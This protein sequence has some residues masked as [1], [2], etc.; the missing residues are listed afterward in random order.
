MATWPWRTRSSANA[1]HLILMPLTSLTKK[2]TKQKKI[3]V[4]AVIVAE[5]GFRS[6]V[7]SR[8]L[9]VQGHAWPPRYWLQLISTSSS[10]NDENLQKKNQ[11]DSIHRGW[12]S[13]GHINIEGGIESRHRSRSSN[14]VT[15]LKMFFFELP[16]G[17]SIGNNSHNI[18]ISL[19]LSQISFETQTVKID[20]HPSF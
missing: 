11:C 2:P 5:I 15:T 16:D 17:Q 20:R 10:Y 4:L 9:E 14:K 19:T 18:N 1:T 6:L 3:M 12:N 8:D 7:W 13:N